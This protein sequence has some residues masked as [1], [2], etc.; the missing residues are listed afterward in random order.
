MANK[1]NLKTLSPS[2][3]RDLGRTGG[4][5]SGEVRRER[6]RL[7]EIA[8]TIAHA[9]LYDPAEEEAIREKYK[10]AGAIYKE[11]KQLYRYGINNPSVME[12]IVYRIA[13][14]AINGN[15]Q[16]AK[17]FLEWTGDLSPKAE[18]DAPGTLTQQEI[19]IAY[20]ASKQE[21]EKK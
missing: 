8:L 20:R 12:Q 14:D 16:A 1:Q 7:R 3:A 9:P 4:I 10:A 11:P 19:S 2:E 15:I 18:L 13:N 6:K 5:V 21:F 17:L